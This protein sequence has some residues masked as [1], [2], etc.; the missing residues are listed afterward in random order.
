MVSCIKKTT[1]AN[2]YSTVQKQPMY[3]FKPVHVALP[4][5]PICQFKP[6]Q[7]SR[8]KELKSLLTVLCTLDCKTLPTALYLNGTFDSFLADLEQK[9]SVLC[10]L[11]CPMA[12][13]LV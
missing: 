8:P 5:R 3:Q 12:Y 6:V 2:T 13:K 7:Q 9:S 1:I 11:L 4:K 10:I